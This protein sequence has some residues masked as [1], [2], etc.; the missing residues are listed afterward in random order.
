LFAEG[1]V[2]I[3]PEVIRKMIV[4]VKLAQVTKKIIEA[5]SIGMAFVVHAQAPFADEAC[6]VASRLQ[7]CCNVTS[8]ERSV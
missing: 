2:E 4:R 5:L 7:H 1:L 3:A 6:F 8:L